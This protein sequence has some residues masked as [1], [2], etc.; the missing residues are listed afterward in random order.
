MLKAAF[1]RQPKLGRFIAHLYQRVSDERLNIVTGAGISIEAGVPLWHPLLQRLSERS[2]ELREDVSAHQDAGLHP[3]YLGQIIYHRH[4]ADH[5]SHEDFDGEYASIEHDWAKDIHSAI[6]QDV[7]ENI[8]DIKESHP[9]LNQLSLLAQKVPLVINFNFD[10]LL[11]ETISHQLSVSNVSKRGLS[12]VWNPPLIDRK[13]STTVFH[14]NGLLPRVSLKKRS[15]YLIFTEDSFA[16]AIAR[17][18]TVSSE[19]LFLRFVQNT[20]L[21]VGHSLSDSSLKDYLRRN[22]EKSPAN[23]HY[24][25]HWLSK[26]DV[27]SERRM[28]DIF[29]ANLELYNVITIFLTSSELCELL[30]VLNM[31]ERDVRDFLENTS[32][33]EISIFRF[34][35]AGPVAS[36]K[37]TLLRQLRCFDT[38]EEWTRSPPKEMYYAHDKISDSDRTLVDEF[39]YSEIKEKNIRMTNTSVGFH[40]MDRAPLDLYAFSKD[41]DEKKQKTNELKIKSFRGRPIQSGEI[42]FITASGQ[43]LVKRNL[44]RGRA[45]EDAGDAEYLEEQGR[46][47]EDLYSPNLIIPSDELTAGDIGRRV[48]RFALL[49]DYTP[50]D[51]AAIMDLYD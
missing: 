34:Y 22:K 23:H 43:C 31:D 41:D 45:P 40:F 2:D 20:M 38:L 8:N 3:E 26:P 24:M 48:A 9:Y 14:V 42:V 27:L 37:S 21:I 39:V 47:L 33:E 29:Q 12:V 11:S 35:I 44:G 18:P 10:D 32:P 4:K 50:I 17:Y 6:Y 25:V 49:E 5:E 36:G 19:F 16:N 13:N 28:Q 1:Q 7:P 46:D 15:P 51:L 30:S